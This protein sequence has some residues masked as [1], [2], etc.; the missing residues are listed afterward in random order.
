[1]NAAKND[2]NRL[3]GDFMNL[4]EM[5]QEQPAAFRWEDLQ[6][7][8]AE[9]AQAYNEGK[10]PSFHVLVF[11]GYAH[12]EFHER[13][14]G[15]LIAAGFDP[16]K[17]VRTAPE[18][19]YV[20]VFGHDGLAMASIENP[21]SA[22]MRDSLYAIARER[23]GESSTMD[24]EALRRIVLFCYE[25]IPKDVLSRIAPEFVSSVPL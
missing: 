18:A 23:F 6:S 17:T 2:I 24:A 25:S 20:A 12:G 5:W 10:G 22:R 14:L 21:V 16:F 19:S 11:D 4:Y 7:L 9:A 1:M 13:L 8:A 15:Y 3:L